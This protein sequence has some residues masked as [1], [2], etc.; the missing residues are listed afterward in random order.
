MNLEKSSNEIQSKI[1]S[2]RKLSSDT[3]IGDLIKNRYIYFLAL[4]GILFYI[5]FAYLPMIGISIAFLDFN[6]IQGI[7]G[8]KFIGL[9]NFDFFFTNG[10]WLKVT[11]NTLLLNVSFITMDLLSQMVVAITL[12]EIAN[13]FI[14]KVTQSMI[15]LPNFISWP[16]VAMFSVVLL[17]SDGGLINSLLTYIGAKPLS[18]YSDPG[19]WPGILIFFRVWKGVGIGSVIYL[20]S[21]AGIDQEMYEAAKIDGASRFQCIIRMTVPMLTSTTIVLAMLSIGRIFY[22]DFGMIYN[23]IGDNPQLYATTDIIDTFVFRNL[24]QLGNIGM[25]SAV[26]LVQST[27]GFIVVMTTNFIIKKINPEYAFF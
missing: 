1:K 21:I 12:S 27:F 17:S 10:D 22:G 11:R 16:V 18:F 15:L 7:F 25:S 13:K 8:S 9:Q 20:A 5:I 19:L 14:K 4:P 23:L 3:V 24:R 26:G 6:P 2:K